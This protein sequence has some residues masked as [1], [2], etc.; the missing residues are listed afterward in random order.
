[1][2]EPAPS[3]PGRD[4]IRDMVE[5][6][7]AAGRHGGRVVTRFP[8]E[9]NGYLH[10]G[11]A[12]SICLNFGLALENG[13]TCNLRL[14]DTNPETEEQ[15]YVEAIRDGV[16]WLGFDWGNNF[17][18]A[19]DYFEQLYD[20]AV[21]LIRR[22]KAY[23]CSLSEDEIRE[24]RGT[25]TEP[26]RNSPYRD[27]TVEEN[28]DLFRRMRAGELADGAH[29]LRGKI[30]MASPNMKMRDPLFYRI[31]RATHYHRGDAWCI[32]P[33]YD[34][35]HPLSDAIEGITH[36]LCTLEFENNREV[37]DWLVDSLPF[38]DPPRQ[39]EFARLNLTYTLMSKRKLLELV[40]RQLVAG[41]D[42][43]RLPT[44]AG[45]RRRGFTPEALRD[46]CERIG[47]A[48]ANSTVDVALLEH[49]LR[50]DLNPRVPR[51]MAVLR[52]LKLVIENYPAGQVEEL[53]APLYPHDVPKEGERKV[54]FSRQLYIER[55]DFAE[56]PPKGFHRLAP[57]REV[58]LRYGYFVRCESVVKDPASGEVVEVRCTYDPATRGGSAPDGRKVPGTLHWVSAAQ[59]LPVEVRIY[60]R[61]FRVERPDLE[62]GDVA[63]RLNPRSLEALTGSRIE[64]AA[65]DPALGERLQFERQGY[66]FRD[67]VDSRP[68]QLV[69]NRIVP[70]RDSWAQEVQKQAAAAPAGAEGVR[71]AVVGT[72]PAGPAGPSLAEAPTGHAA[73]VHEAKGREGRVREAKGREA[74]GEHG[75]GAEGQEANVKEPKVPA[76]LSA[77]EAELLER[78][79]PELLPIVQGVLAAH[80]AEV[81]RYRNGKT[82]VL[83]FLVAQVMKQASQG[84]G[85]PNP[86]LVNVMV[87]RE[88]GSL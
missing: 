51:V 83:G 77:E 20:F 70:L 23:V 49:C 17:F 54:P 78:V 28:L 13:G 56:Q 27:R 32:Y 66:F 67:P 58:R 11:H 9:P 82:G 6:D 88:L 35:A 7:R 30:D 40:E 22:G 72:E 41:W 44:L 81:E 19:S 75:K 55:E 61:L 2:S 86:K 3:T 10:I 4:F 73:E 1:M 80:P 8:P 68:G 16:R 26:G 5:R 48:K 62:E 36:S 24:Y 43:P 21:E 57:G 63:A 52:P 25:V 14:D 60:D 47:V 84:G 74:K 64:P 85:K 31:K 59:S 50:E 38:A 15:E 34:F 42:D 45:L 39:T 65:A 33:L 69:F 76:P 12:K 46:F 71:K 87:T 53:E 29:V 79:R 18:H 37:Y